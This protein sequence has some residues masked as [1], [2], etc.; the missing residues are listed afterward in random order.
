[1]MSH[2]LLLLGNALPCPCVCGACASCRTTAGDRGGEVEAIKRGLLRDKH[3]NVQV[4]DMIGE[5][6]FGKVYRGGWCGCALWALCALRV[7]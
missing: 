4:M 6:S 3:L 2:H 5:G 7:S 1:M